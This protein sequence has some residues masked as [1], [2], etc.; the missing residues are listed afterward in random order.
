MGEAVGK[1]REKRMERRQTCCRKIMHD[2]PCF[3]LILLYFMPDFLLIFTRRDTLSVLKNV[4]IGIGAFIH[5]S[6][7]YAR[8][9][10]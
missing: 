10:S 3:S 5:I 8:L 6:K 1:D 7:A 4:T 2:Y 9:V